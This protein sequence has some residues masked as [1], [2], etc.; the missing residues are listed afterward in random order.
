MNDTISRQA[1]IDAIEESRWERFTRGDYFQV[2]AVDALEEATLIIKS[3]PSAQQEQRWIP[4]SQRLPEKG[5][6]CLV[7][8]EGVI[9]IDKYLGI[10]NPLNWDWYDRDYE[11]WMPLPEPYKGEIYD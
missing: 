10:G 2:F 8:D 7:C 3:I 1:A 5:Q 6:T 11:A 4:V 9:A